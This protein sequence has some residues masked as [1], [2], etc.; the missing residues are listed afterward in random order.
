MDIDYLVIEKYKNKKGEETTELKEH[1]GTLIIKQYYGINSDNFIIKK[2][3][4]IKKK[5]CFSFFKLNGIYYVSINGE[6]IIDYKRFI[7]IEQISKVQDTNHIKLKNS[8][9]GEIILYN[10]DTDI[11]QKALKVMDIY[12]KSKANYIT[13][14]KEFINFVFN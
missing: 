10:C 12:I 4:T 1:D 5:L 3:D 6:H 13:N 14:I 2:I 11:L 7:K 9:I 8:H